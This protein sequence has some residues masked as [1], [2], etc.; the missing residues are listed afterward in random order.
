MLQFDPTIESFY[1]EQ[2][3]IRVFFTPMLIHRI[4]DMVAFGIYG[5]MGW[6][7]DVGDATMVRDFATSDKFLSLIPSQWRIAIEG[8]KVPDGTEFGVGVA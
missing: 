8:G 5:K 3:H 4:C 6:E 7:L 1:L 2:N